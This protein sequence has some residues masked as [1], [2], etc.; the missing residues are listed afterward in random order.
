MWWKVVILFFFFE[1]DAGHIACANYLCISL[2]PREI[3]GQHH[4]GGD[5]MESQDKAK[6][7]R[8]V[9]ASLSK[10]THTWHHLPI[11]LQDF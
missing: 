4:W 10:D 11:D 3:S 5:A 9:N 8:R 2:T 7:H 6:N 1:E